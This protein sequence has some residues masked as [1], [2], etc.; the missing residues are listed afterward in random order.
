M[1]SLQ[2]IASSTDAEIDDG[3]DGI[4]FGLLS[5]L[6]DLEAGTINEVGMVSARLDKTSDELLA[7]GR[8]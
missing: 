1:L 5:V 2:T 7:R 6:G 4:R 3:L 8:Y